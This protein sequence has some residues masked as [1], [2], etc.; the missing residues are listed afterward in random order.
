MRK[1]GQTMASQKKKAPAKS[2]SG[3][4]KWLLWGVVGLALVAVIALLVIPKGGTT[5]AG[6]V[7]GPTGVQDVSAAD[8]QKAVD[9]GYQLIDVRTAQ[10]YAQGH[11][12]GAVNIPIDVLPASVAQIDKSKP[13]ALYCA[14]GARSLNAKQF[15]AAQGYSTVINLAQGIASWTGKTVQ[16]TEP[17]SSG[18]AASSGGAP[19][20]GSGAAVVVKT[21]GKPVFVDLYTDY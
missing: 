20:G 10:E 3:L 1:D 4:T 8:F 14:S 19:S 9:A 11:I 6:S 16:G 18:Q 13:V 12:P 5:S 15:L 17:G 21:S 7:A 2:S